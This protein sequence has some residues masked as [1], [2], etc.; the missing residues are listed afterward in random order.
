[1]TDLAHVMGQDLS[2]GPTGDFALVDGADETTQRLLRRLLTNPHGYLWRSDYGAGL[3][4]FVGQ[5]AQETRI[6]A[7]ARAQVF[8]EAAVAQVPAPVIGVTSYPDGTVALDVSYADAGT[9]ATFAL[10]T[11]T[12]A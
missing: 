10:P 11:Q 5:P 7:I 1:M 3:A 12:L 9:G 6:A 2:F 8:M 4:A